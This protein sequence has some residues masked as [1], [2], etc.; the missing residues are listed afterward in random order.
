[1][2]DASVIY[3]IGIKVIKLY[4]ATLVAEEIPKEIRDEITAWTHNR[5]VYMLP[6]V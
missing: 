4:H 2:T 3:T 5:A 1:M 6:H